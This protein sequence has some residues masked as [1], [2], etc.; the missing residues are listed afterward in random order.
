MAPWP[1]TRA[2]SAR[3]SSPL[4]CRQQAPKAPAAAATFGRKLNMPC[5]GRTRLVLPSPSIALLPPA[6]L[7]VPVL[8]RRCKLPYSTDAFLLN[9][10]NLSQGA[11]LLLFVTSPIRHP[12][13]PVSNGAVS[14]RKPTRPLS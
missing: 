8:K 3:T 6:A 7:S 1:R 13:E 11:H 5:P 4:P 2:N 10:R 14:F 9:R 12:P